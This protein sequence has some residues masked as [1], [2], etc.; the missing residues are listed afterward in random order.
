[1]REKTGSGDETG[2]GRGAVSEL[3]RVAHLSSGHHAD[4]A[5]VFWKE[6]L[7]LARAGYD[8]SL[9]VP[10]EYPS[11]LPGLPPE[12]QVSVVRN[13]PGR[14][15]R[16]VVT[17]WALLAAGRRRKADIYH[18]HEPEL[19]PIGLLLRLSGKKVVYDV[20]EDVP[21]DIL[22]K[23]WIPVGFRGLVAAAAGTLEWIAGRAL[24][25]VIAATPTIARRFPSDHTALVQNFARIS[26]FGTSAA[27]ECDDC[28]ALTYIGGITADR[29]AP[30][31]VQA[32]ARLERFPRVRL[33]MAGPIH[34]PDLQDTL[35]ALPGW[36]QV[37]YR[38]HQGRPGILDILKTARIGLVLFHSSQNYIEAI[39]VKLF[40][41]MAAGMPVIAADF[42]RLREIVEGN[43][44]GFCVPS[45]DVAAVAQAIDWLLAHP[46]E[47]DEM[48]RRGREAAMNMFSWESEERAL[49]R[50]YRHLT[51][52]RIGRVPP[53]A[54]SDPDRRAVTD[55]EARRIRAVYAE[56]EQSVAGT[57]KADEDNPGN[58]AIVHERHRR[59]ARVLDDRFAK[60]LPHC[61]ILDVGCG[62]GAVLDWFHQLGVPAS[63]L[64]GVDLVPSRIE[65]ARNAYPGYTFQVG[66]AERLDFPSRWFDLVAV[67]TVFSSVLDRNMA[68]NLAETIGRVLAPDGA[69]VWY[70]MRWPNP[71]NP[72]LRAMT[73]ER[74][75]KLFPGFELE[76]EPINLLPPL[77]RRLGGL[78]GLAYPVLASVRPL[79]TH[80]VGLLRPPAVRPMQRSISLFESQ[81]RHA[82]RDAVHD[83]RETDSTSA[84]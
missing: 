63:H 83:Q 68:E 56:R 61:R 78:T 47:A 62:S 74:I 27:R 7:S 15:G 40:E 1:M 49:L 4:D 26:E 84:G 59:L 3:V 31:M 70:D 41:Y 39:P 2:R 13:R 51:E 18:I 79:R 57:L 67:F 21:R 10:E 29:C 30:E 77:A 33:I 43:R 73:R 58:L 66:N 9:T 64:F 72:N 81:L 25:G 45:R 50:F 54:R 76:L 32:L 24:S 14:F 34:P 35:V 28:P 8:V 55:A 22:V 36:R 53:R 71:F 23:S 37:D 46:A 11:R 82:E 12:V 44:C 16:L 6:C 19:L 5:R 65:A 17:P 75:R 52:G 48:G 20:H 42:P 38:G 80:L 69:V 60:P